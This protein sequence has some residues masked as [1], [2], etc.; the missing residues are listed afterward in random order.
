[1]GQ[2]FRDKTDEELADLASREVGSG[3]SLYM[4]APPAQVEML[5]R[6]KAAIQENTDTLRVSGEVTTRLNRILVWLTVAIFLL[7]AVMTV[8]SLVGLLVP[9]RSR[10]L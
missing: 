2:S 10:L 7:T 4:H 8:A 1:M 5:R 9:T 6:L 3:S